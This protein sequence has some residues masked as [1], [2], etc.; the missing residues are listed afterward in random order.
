MAQDRKELFRRDIRRALGMLRVK[1]DA[2]GTGLDEDYVTRKFRSACVWLS[3]GVMSHFDPMDWDQLSLHQRSELKRSVAKFRKLAEAVNPRDAVTGK[4]VSKPVTRAQQ[5]EAEKSL[6]AV[7]RII[8]ED[9]PNRVRSL[10]E[11]ILAVAASHGASNVRLFGSVARNTSG[12]QSDV[13]LLVDLAPGRSLFDL[14][15]LVVNLQNL[16]GC[17]VDVATANGLRES[18]R[19]RI[20]KE[21]RPL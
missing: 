16:L 10:R 2:T 12:V 1:V 8:G 3:R 11:E 19:D 5:T 21:A 7:A 17:K 18:V 9:I 20:L 4:A 6:L 15:A 13:D 14:G